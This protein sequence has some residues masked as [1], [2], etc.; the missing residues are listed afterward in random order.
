MIKITNEYPDIT[1]VVQSAGDTVVL[2]PGASVPF[3]VH[4]PRDVDLRRAFVA[5]KVAK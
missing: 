3:S 1:I 2:T 5:V 4:L